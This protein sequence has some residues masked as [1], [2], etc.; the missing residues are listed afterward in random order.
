MKKSPS[1]TQPFL[2][3]DESVGQTSLRRRRM[4][5]F[6]LSLL[7]IALGLVAATYI[8]RKAPKA[9]KHIPAR[10]VPLVEAQVVQTGHHRVTVPAMGTVVPARE[11]VLRSQ[12]SGEVLSLNPEFIEGVE[13]TSFNS[14]TSSLRA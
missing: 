13:T 14:S 10:V 12:V 2:T 9:Q 8:T 4:L 7:V 3:D 1:E 6:L 5:Q 11:V